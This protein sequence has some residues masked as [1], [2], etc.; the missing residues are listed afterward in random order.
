MIDAR[1][2]VVSTLKGGVR[3]TTTTLLTAWAMGNHGDDVLVIDA[4]AYTQGVTDWISTA[5]M[6]A[7]G[8]GIPFHVA[9]WSPRLGLL[10]PFI[11]DQVKRTGARVVLVDVGGEAPE[12]LAQAASLARA[13]GGAVIS[14]VGAEQAEVGRLAATREIVQQ[15]GAQ[16]AV[17]LT[18]VPA[19]GRGAARAVREDLTAAGFTVLPT[20]VEQNRARYSDIWGTI[21]ADLGAYTAVAGDVAQLRAVA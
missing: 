1:V 4:D 21:P 5:W 13:T 3:K 14:P 8:Q 7:D 15:N 19:P 12:V 9:Q 10:V 16:M 2:Y 18:R 17:L 20:E 6:V 11:S